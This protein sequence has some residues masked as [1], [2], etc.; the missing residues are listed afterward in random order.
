M[1]Q[2]G[3]AAGEHAR[4]DG[5]GR[6]WPRRRTPRRLRGWYRSQPPPGTRMR[7]GCRGQ[8]RAHP[9]ANGASVYVRILS[10]LIPAAFRRPPARPEGARERPPRRRGARLPARGGRHPPSAG[11][12]RRD[13]AR[14]RP[15]ADGSRPR[16]GDGARARAGRARQQPR[17]H[18]RDRARAARPPRP[19]VRPRPAH[20]VPRP[21]QGPRGSRR[22][23]VAPVAAAPH[24]AARGHRGRVGGHRPRLGH[25][26]GRLPRPD[27]GGDRRTTLLP[28]GSSS[29]MPS[30]PGRR[31][32]R[33]SSGSANR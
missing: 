2:A 26:D 21:D 6:R 11:L 13:P 3:D 5:T 31:S 15:R 9:P 17:R 16:R 10:G 1:T 28:T 32:T 23:R 20:H 12:P 27:G 33:R 18:A 4:Q 8:R 7:C 29:T 24:P 30:A 25:G 14:R 19:G 22:R